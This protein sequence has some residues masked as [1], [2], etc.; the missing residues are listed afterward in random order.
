MKSGFEDRRKVYAVIA[1]AAVA[2]FLLFRMS[3]SGNM[4]QV[5][6]S[7]SRVA[8]QPLRAPASTGRGA[9]GPKSASPSLDPTL[10]LNALKNIEST[11]YKGAGRN[12]FEFAQERPPDLPKPK[13][14]PTC[15]PNC[16]PPPPPPINLKFYGFANRPGEPTSVFLAEGE[17]IFIGREGDIINRR[18]KIIRI[19][20]ASVEIE[21]M[22]NNNR[23]TIPLTQS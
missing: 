23:Q 12:I 8:Q 3:T 2:V 15:E 20:K 13:P 10:R 16:P 6:A 21:D 4:S 17:D 9:K 7:S 11:N 5:S 1:L 22:P 14:L 19:G 18:Y